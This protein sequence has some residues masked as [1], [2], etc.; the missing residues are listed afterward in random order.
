MKRG[1]ITFDNDL[2]DCLKRP[3]KPVPE[4]ENCRALIEY[5]FE[6]MGYPKGIGLAAPQIGEMKRIIVIQVPHTKAGRMLGGCTKHHIINPVLTWH[7]KGMVLGPEGCLSF[8]GEQVIV[9]RYDRIKVQGF[10]IRWNP[11]TIGGKGLVARVLQHEMDHLDGRTLDTYK[12]IMEEEDR[13]SGIIRK[14]GEVATPITD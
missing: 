11:I 3:A 12:K 14:P 4:N 6:A 13:K 7:S 10:D 9:P 2:R 5:M 8:P 1:I